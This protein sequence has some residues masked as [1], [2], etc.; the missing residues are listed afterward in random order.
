MAP[1]AKMVPDPW[2]RGYKLPDTERNVR[3]L[4]M[5][6]FYQL[7]RN[8]KEKLK[9]KKWAGKLCSITLYEYTSTRNRRYL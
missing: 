7:K 4:V 5:T 6:F 2:A 8:T 1:L 3:N 9:M